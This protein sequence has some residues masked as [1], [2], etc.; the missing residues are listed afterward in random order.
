MTSMG[1]AVRGERVYPGLL[2]AAPTELSCKVVSK[3]D[4][5]Q[6]GGGS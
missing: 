5:V 6:V 4:Q 3:S 2:L 1:V